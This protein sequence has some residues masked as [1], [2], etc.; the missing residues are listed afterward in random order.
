MILS[1]QIRI[2]KRKLQFPVKYLI[3]AVTI[4]SVERIGLVTF[5]LIRNVPKPALEIRYF[6]ILQRH[7]V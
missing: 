7:I 1:P 2:F 4:T 5:S 3:K 6:S